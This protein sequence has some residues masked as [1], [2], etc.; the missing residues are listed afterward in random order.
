MGPLEEPR[1]I[2]LLYSWM[3]NEYELLVFLLVAPVVGI[4]LGMLWLV[5]VLFVGRGPGRWAKTVLDRHRT[6]RREN[7]NW[8]GHSRFRWWHLQQVLRLQVLYLAFV[9]ATCGLGLLVGAPFYI[10]WFKRAR[11]VAEA[12]GWPLLPIVGRWQP[13]PPA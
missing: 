2:G 4:L 8:L 10:A 6:R 3:N 1:S 13:E 9:I 7:G 12:G 5:R 11:A